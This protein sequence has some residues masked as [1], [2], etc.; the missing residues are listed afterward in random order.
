MC[1]TFGHVSHLSSHFKERPSTP[2]TDMHLLWSLHAE[3]RE[4][5]SYHAPSGDHLVPSGKVLVTQILSSPAHPKKLN[6]YYFPAF[7]KRRSQ[8]VIEWDPRLCTGV[9]DYEIPSNNSI[10]GNIKI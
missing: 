2:V 8:A 4:V 10:I 5:N 1:P 7:Q 3:R 6:L 9:H